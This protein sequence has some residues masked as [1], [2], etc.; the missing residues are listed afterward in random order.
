MGIPG[1][2]DI[3]SSRIILT[4]GSVSFLCKNTRLSAYENAWSHLILARLLY[5]LPN[6][7]DEETE[8]PRIKQAVQGHSWYQ[9][10]D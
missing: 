1:S 4:F 10:R 3:L 8:T 2:L 7:T 9:S 5:H 6:Y